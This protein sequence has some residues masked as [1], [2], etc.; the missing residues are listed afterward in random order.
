MTGPHP[1]PIL[2]AQLS[3]VRNGSIYSILSKI[4]VP[5]LTAHFSSRHEYQKQAFPVN[6]LMD[7]LL[8]PNSDLD[9]DIEQARQRLVFRYESKCAISHAVIGDSPEAGGQWADGIDSEEALALSYADMLALPG[10]SIARHFKGDTSAFDRL[11]RTQVRQY[12]AAYPKAVGIEGR[13]F[14]S[15]HVVNV[16][17]KGDGFVLDISHNGQTSKLDCNTVVLA[18]GLF[19]NHL[20]PPPTL[21][22]F[23]PLQNPQKDGPVLVVGSGFSAADIILHAMSQ[24]RPVIHMYKWQT[25]DRPNPLLACHPQAY[26][27]YAKVYQLMKRTQATGYLGLPNGHIIKGIDSRHRGLYLRISSD[28][29]EYD[30]LISEVKIAIGRRA[31]LDYLSEEIRSAFGQVFDENNFVTRQGFTT[32]IFRSLGE[33]QSFKIGRDMY[34]IGSLVGDSSL[35]RFGLGGVVACAADIVTSK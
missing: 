11:S 25:K 23:L 28:K 3:Q 33:H 10:Y 12:Y 16:S 34:V 18:S 17:R 32:Q 6:I 24:R 19:S 30:G 13:L 35:V 7:A 9:P 26:P 29:N 21:E 1:D 5:V 22:R 20:P 15:A 31:R 8:R 2:H 4:T 27:E 14:S